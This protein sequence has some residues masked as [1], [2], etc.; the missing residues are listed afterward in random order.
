MLLRP[1]VG[2]HASCSA[3][4]VPQFCRQDRQRVLMVGKRIQGG[5]FPT[6]GLDAQHFATRGR[7]TCAVRCVYAPLMGPPGRVSSISPKTT[8]GPVTAAV[9]GPISAISRATSGGG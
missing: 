8:A 5:H 2:F 3:V 6:V 4:E 1:F 7:Y 9:S